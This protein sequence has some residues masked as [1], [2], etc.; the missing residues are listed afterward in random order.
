[1]MGEGKTCKC[2][3]HNMV[4]LL[5]VLFGVLFLLNAFMLVSNYIT[6]IVWPILVIAAGGTKMGMCKCCAK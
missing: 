2:M 3:H 4:P 6:A 5:V 1:M